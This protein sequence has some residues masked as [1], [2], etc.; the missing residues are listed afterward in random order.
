MHP[1]F[2]D[3]TSGS[4]MDFTY[5]QLGVSYTFALELRDKGDKG[6]FLPESQI[7]QTAI[8][9]LSGVKAM[10]AKMEDYSKEW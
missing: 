6:F 3:K 4:A 1:F 5:G 2:L 10:V 9:T 7:I 8:E